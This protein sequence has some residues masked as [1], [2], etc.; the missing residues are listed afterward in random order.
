MDVMKFIISALLPIL[1]TGLLIYLKDR[2]RI[3][4]LGYWQKQTAIGILFGLFSIL[5]TELGIEI[6]HAIINTRSAAPIVAGLAFGGPAGIL[7]GII[8][9]I[10]RWLCVYWSGGSYTRLACSLAT[11][12][13]GFFTAW[14]RSSLFKKQK[15]F[16]Y[17]GLIIS[18]ITEVF[19]M[20]L[21]FITNMDDL[22]KAFGVVR[23]CTVPMVTVT[24]ITVA[25][26]LLLAEHL[27]HQ[28]VADGRQTLAGC[29]Q[30]WLF[31]CVSGALCLTTV[32]TLFLQT[33]ISREDAASVMQI[34]IADV[35]DSVRST[36]DRNL[37]YL[38]E[39]LTR[40]LDRMES[41]STED[42]NRLKEFYDVAEI[43]LIDKGGH[44]YDST[45]PQYIGFF[46]RSGQQ[47]QDF[48]AEVTKNGS[49]VQKYQKVTHELAAYMKY[50]GKRLKTGNY[51][52]VGYDT[53]QFQTSVSNS[54]KGITDFRHVGK[55]GYL[56]VLDKEMK[57]VSDPTGHVGGSMEDLGLTE[58]LLDFKTNTL[59]AGTVFGEPGLWMYDVTEGYRIL[60]FLPEIEAMQFRDMSVYI[61]TLMQ[62]I[63]SAS[64]FLLIYFL[65]K[66]MIVSNIHRI[67]HSLGEITEGNLN[68]TV[69]VH[70]NEE[71][72]ALSKD[73]N[74]TVDTL[75]T[76]IDEAAARIDRELEIASTIQLSSL[77]H[78]F[79]PESQKY[80]YD[81]YATMTPAKE[82]GGDFYDFYMLDDHRLAV[83]V[84]DVS[85]KGIT[86][87]MFMMRAKSLIKGYTKLGYDL[88]K[89][90]ALANEDLCRSNE[91][92]MFVTCWMGI[93]DFE[94]YEL[95]FV[96]AGH[97]PPLIRIGQ[98]PYRYHR[99]RPCFVLGGMD[100][101]RYRMETT[102]LSPDSGLFLYTDGITEA[103]N[104]H[105]ELYGDDRLELALGNCSRI[106]SRKI[107]DRVSADTAVFVGRA[108][109]FDDMT[110]LSL[111]L[112]QD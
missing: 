89:V 101:V 60:A 7:A 84:A 100:G 57:I 41:C 3:A 11:V 31:I 32:F 13:A 87:A 53:D 97:N 65:L 16:W 95:Q 68:V 4:A 61:T 76:Y 110:M 62:T 75:K 58:N 28:R 9:G 71:F 66:N 21:V 19:H 15:V 40:D 55:Q 72:S 48:W 22:S 54:V 102:K 67:N 109:Q 49:T 80:P 44:I 25:L 47:S 17:Y 85:G 50:A 26:S 83:L 79:E 64:L 42:L 46:M 45:T 74:H 103:T 35:A 5:G 27:S 43:N 12:L 14:V 86:A 88:G 23:S 90:F 107:C 77:P 108:P 33:R 105:N 63:V 104:A 93:L 81:I 70:N 99:T 10:E 34:Y 98:E 39:R 69:D 2:P 82:V 8:G 37:M 1:G 29:F 51:V 20:L 92:E 18:C 24:G 78:I 112:T 59:H 30:R 6:D 73:I 106:S 56:L 96:N 94:T 36:S 91:A 38:T 111:R 52:Q